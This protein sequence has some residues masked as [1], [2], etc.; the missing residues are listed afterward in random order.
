MLAGVM[1]A[2]GRELG[3]LM[4][5]YNRI[6]TAGC[7]V[8]A[9]TAGR[10]R[11]VPGLGPQVFYQ[12]SDHDAARVVRGVTLTAEVLFAAGARRVLLPFDG[13]PAV[14]SMD[15]LRGLLAR[16]VA[17]RSTQAVHRPPDGHRTDE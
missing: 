2:H 14:H 13:A 7:V 15:E 6:V 3:E 16:P 8:T 9:S 11:A 4:A 17:K 1:P 10:V 12:I 5:G